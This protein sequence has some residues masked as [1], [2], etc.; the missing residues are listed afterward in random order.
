MVWWRSICAV[1]EFIHLN[2]T[3]E[4]IS[5]PQQWEICSVS[6]DLHFF[7]ISFVPREHSLLRWSSRV[8]RDFFLSSFCAC[9]EAN[10]DLS[11]K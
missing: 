1:E 9:N 7:D 4:A 3:V 6:Y 11:Q 2:V 5:G 10:K 8:S